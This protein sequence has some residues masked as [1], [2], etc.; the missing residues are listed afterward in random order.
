MSGLPEIDGVA[1]D[2]F[3][4]CVMAREVRDGDWVSHGASVPLAGAALYSAI[5][6]HA[7]NVDFW[8]QGCVNPA[9]RNLAEALTAPE[10]IYTTTRAHMSQ[11]A[12]IDFSLRGNS[13][14]QFL[15][16]LQIDPFCNVNVS[17]VPR[18]GKPPL[19][20]HGIAVADAI[21]AV[22]RTCLYVTEHS[23]RVL[24]EELPFRTG[25]GH[26]D[27]SVWREASGL[28]PDAGPQAVITPLAVL[29][30]GDD[31]RLRVASVHRGTTL[32]Q[33]R[34]A[35]GFEIEAAPDVAET[36]MPTAEE[37]A[38]LDSVDP[39]RIRRLEFRETRA[40]ILRLLAER[41][42]G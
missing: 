1:L 41:A 4:P 30:V 20:F 7:P 14:F 5:E 37:R 6:T 18:T 13:M 27:G 8:I 34:A 3:M 40:E 36:P 39:E 32:E 9:N 31:R 28:P 11:T 21:N 25:A 19:R 38:A 17:T 2:D 33:V 15:R 12:I 23:P 10:R 26:D 22:R 16:P 24:V 35:T 42:G 29:R